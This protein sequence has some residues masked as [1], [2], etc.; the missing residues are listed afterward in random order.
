MSLLPWADIQSCWRS[1]AETVAIPERPVVRENVPVRTEADIFAL[2]WMRKL[3]QARADAQG[4]EREA[5][6]AFE[7]SLAAAL[8]PVRERL[9]ALRQGKARCTDVEGILARS[10]MEDRSTLSI[11]ISDGVSDCSGEKPDQPEAPGQ[12]KVLLVLVPTSGDGGEARVSLADRRK[13]IRS[14]MP[15]VQVVFGFAL[16]GGPEAWLGGHLAQA[17]TKG[18]LEPAGGR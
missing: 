12:G 16:S 11:V 14:R 18:S 7:E 13:A 3:A 6:Q 2:S 1:P 8:R 15:W 10:A 9:T 4:R 5:A 17:W